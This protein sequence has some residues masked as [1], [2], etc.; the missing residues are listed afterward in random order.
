MALFATMGP[1][2]P[3]YFMAHRPKSGHM[4]MVLYLGVGNFSHHS[5][6]KWVAL[7]VGCLHLM[8]FSPHLVSLSQH[9]VVLVP[10]LIIWPLSATFKHGSTKVLVAF[11]VQNLTSY[12]WQRE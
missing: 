1:H 12:K 11:Y 8:Q 7:W 6:L 5:G 9:A 3:E 10:S 2:M 4:D